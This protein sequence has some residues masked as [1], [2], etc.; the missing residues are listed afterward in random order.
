MAM[1]PRILSV[2]QPSFLTPADKGIYS[3]KS[4]DSI[5][6]QSNVVLRRGAFVLYGMVQHGGTYEA[7]FIHS[8]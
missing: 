5:K 4:I 1:D 7:L 3:V 8:I 6:L 2:G